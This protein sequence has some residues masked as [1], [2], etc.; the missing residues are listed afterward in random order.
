MWSTVLWVRGCLNF[1][2]HSML[3]SQFSPNP[4]PWNTG[5]QCFLLAKVCSTVYFKIKACQP[6]LASA[7][8][9]HNSW[10]SA[11]EMTGL[12]GGHINQE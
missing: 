3:S 11:L 5:D 12:R 9:S 4:A 7:P 1:S 10:P 2:T 6:T 8:G